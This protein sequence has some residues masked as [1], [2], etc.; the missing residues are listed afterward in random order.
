M[1]VVKLKIS[2]EKLTELCLAKYLQPSEFEL[3]G[4]DVKDYDYSSSEEWKAQ[5]SISDKAYKKLK[6]IEFYIRQK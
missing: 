1:E 2:K 3:I 4:V 6:E 5:K